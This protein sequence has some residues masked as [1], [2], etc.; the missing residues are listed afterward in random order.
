MIEITVRPQLD[1]DS[2]STTQLSEGIECVS[3]Q[4]KAEACMRHG[5][6]ARGSV[7]QAYRFEG[8]DVKGAEQWMRDQGITEFKVK[9]GSKKPAAKKKTPTKGKKSS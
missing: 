6:R 8:N 3:G 9:G 4:M 7:I 5:L 2:L 1:F